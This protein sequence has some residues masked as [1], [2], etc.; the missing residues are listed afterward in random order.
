MPSS[1]QPTA[2]SHTVIPAPPSGV[3]AADLA[4]DST[5]PQVL[6]ELLDRARER[7][8]FYESFD[9]IIGENIRRSGELMV[10]T[11]ALRE[12][13]QVLAARSAEERATLA[14]KR[15]AERDHYRALI[16]Q[17]LHEVSS[18]R[19][20]IDTMVTRLESV[21][22]ELGEGEETDSGA[23]A[24]A[25][26]TSIST[27]S[28][29]VESRST[30]PDRQEAT[31]LAP[32]FSSEEPTTDTDGEAPV[33]EPAV[34]TADTAVEE[35]TSN[36]EAE[37]AVT[38]E[39]PTTDGPRSI[40]VLAHGVPSARVAISLQKVLRDLDVVSSVEAREFANGELRLAVQAT[41]ALP[42]ATLES[43]LADNNG[44]LTGSGAT[45]TEITF[46]GA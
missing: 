10:E 11:V 13:A 46:H 38:S 40:D 17:A 8:A 29:L 45:V 24:T 28:A 41:D 6:R 42:Q 43:W 14:A 18:V 1:D 12:Q 9:R 22:A 4:T 2:P 5:D 32:K 21:L 44:E 37:T 31:E 36:V 27:I 3:G 20:V 16:A 23:A 26:A 25:S 19:P 39:S 7:L 30:P 35:E 33:E 15:Q 34:E